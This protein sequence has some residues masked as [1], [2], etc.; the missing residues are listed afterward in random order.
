MH[1]KTKTIRT[2]GNPVYDPDG[3]DKH[4][5]KISGCPSL[6]EMVEIALSVTGHLLRRLH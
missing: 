6:D 1:L 3:S 2:C 4:I 5:I